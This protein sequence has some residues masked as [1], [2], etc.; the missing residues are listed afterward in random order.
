MFPLPHIPV[1]FH[2]LLLLLMMLLCLRTRKLT[3][4]ATFAAALIGTLVYL[5][6]QERGVLMLLTFFLLSVLATSHQKTM[7][8]KL[9]GG[10]L[11]P[12]GRNA[13]QVF[14]NGGAAALLALLCLVDPAQASIY[15]IMIA[16]SL[17]SALADTLSSELG[18]VYGSR[19]FH[20]LTFRKDSRGLDGVISIE[21]TV[22]GALGASFAGLLFAGLNHVAVYIAL[23]GIAGNLLDSVLGALLERKGLIGNDVVNF[24]NTVFAALISL[25]LLYCC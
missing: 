9:A 19:F 4:G 18:T 11:H 10:T 16:A 14:A 22:I 8:S 12:E 23:A 7:K 21:G 25:L 15:R 1:V 24:L 2:V 17:A 5:A 20:V 13:G 6:D 3:L